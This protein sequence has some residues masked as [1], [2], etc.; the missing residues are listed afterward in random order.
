MILSVIV[1]P[2]SAQKGD[3][4]PLLSSGPRWQSFLLITSIYIRVCD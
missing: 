1:K 2:G 3:S 4:V